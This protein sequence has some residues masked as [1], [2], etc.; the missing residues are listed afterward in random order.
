MPRM[1]VVIMFLPTLLG[2]RRTSRSSVKVELVEAN[3][4]WERITAHRIKYDSHIRQCISIAALIYRRSMYTSTRTHPCKST[5]T[6]T[7]SIR[8]RGRQAGGAT[9]CLNLTKAPFEHSCIGGAYEH[10]GTKHFWRAVAYLF[11]PCL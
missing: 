11:H 10:M 9:I 3:T 2:N 1:E 6:F 7:C 5:Y 8:N 4:R